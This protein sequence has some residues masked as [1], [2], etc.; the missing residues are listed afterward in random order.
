VKDFLIRALG[1]AIFKDIKWNSF[2][3][4]VFDGKMFL[5]YLELKYLETKY[6]ELKYLELK[7][8]ETKYLELK[9]FELKYDALH[10]IL[11]LYSKQVFFFDYSLGGYSHRER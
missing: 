4:L 10:Y 5:K 1:A 3:E 2:G 6:L 8:L 9:Y 7:Y 11:S